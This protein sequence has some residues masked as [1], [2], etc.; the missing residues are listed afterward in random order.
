MIFVKKMQLYNAMNRLDLLQEAFA[1]STF[2]ADSCKITKYHLYA[3]EELLAI[4]QSR[5][6]FRRIAE[7]KKKLDSLNKI[8][9]REENIASLHDQKENI[10]LAEKDKELQSEQTSNGYLT[11]FLGGLVFVTLVLVGWLLIYRRQKR[12]METEANRMKA[13]LEGY[14]TLSRTIA[15]AKAELEQER[16]KV[17]SDRQR[18]V[19]DCMAEGMSNKQI[20]DKLFISENT[21]KY[22]IKNIY[23]LLEIKDRKDF[24]V[25]LKK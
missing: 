8:Y 14:L 22:H 10:L 7:T 18:D 25:Q 16:L 17:L 20:A 9:A 12:R 5:N 1:K 13:E 4:Y 23:Q 2:Q 11:I 15:P 6:D 21:V 19:L 24:L 3:H